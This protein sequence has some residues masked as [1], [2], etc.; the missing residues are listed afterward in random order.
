MI[1]DTGIPSPRGRCKEP[2]L[3]A[4]HQRKWAS[5]GGSQ[6][7]QGLPSS[8]HDSWFRRVLSRQAS[9]HAH[10]IGETLCSAD[11]A[12][13]LT[14]GQFELCFSCSSLSKA[15]AIH[16]HLVIAVTIANCCHPQ[17]QSTCECSWKQL[18]FRSPFEEWKPR[19]R[20]AW[21]EDARAILLFPTVRDK[22]QTVTI[23]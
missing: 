11:L 8:E 9:P 20:L 7:F 2:R 13:S 16:F 14:L 5:S 18:S 6:V 19:A 17:Y 21:E 4:T 10:N 12:V 23:T 3:R 15:V 1:K 22:K